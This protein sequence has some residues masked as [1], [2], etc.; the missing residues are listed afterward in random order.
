MTLKGYFKKAKQ[1]V[2]LRY[3]LWRE[4]RESGAGFN[5]LDRRYRTNPYPLYAKLREKDP[6]HRSKLFDGWVLTRYDDIVAA[7]RDSRFSAD[8][9]KRTDYMANRHEMIKAGIIDPEDEQKPSMLRLDPPDHTR[10]RS[11][12]NKAFTP[13]AVE[14]LRPRIE[15][16]VAEV[17]DVA[18]ASGRM[19][20]IRDLA[21]RLP[22]VVIAEM[23]GVPGEDREKFKHWSDE[24][25]KGLDF[26]DD[27]EKIRQARAAGDEL[28]EYLTGIAEER[29]KEPRDDLLSASWPRSRRGTA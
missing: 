2:G 4:T 25:V 20:L 18:E 17:L 1:F 23:L 27:Y 13:R 8:D 16:I 26:S 5:P 7:L 11:L 21:Y 29:R 10:L 15:G 6:F 9:R 22:V 28:M 12:V 19:D 14:A 24:V 3:L